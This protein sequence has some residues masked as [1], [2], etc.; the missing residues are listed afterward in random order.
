V[1]FA[2]KWG[3]HGSGDGQFII[4]D[5]VA[6][7]SSGNVYVADAFNHRIQKFQLANPC[8]SSTTQLTPKIIKTKTT[9]SF[10]VRVFLRILDTITAIYKI[11]INIQLYGNGTNKEIATVTR[12]RITPMIKTSTYHLLPNTQAG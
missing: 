8:P 9:A 3:S 5:G 6:V 10:I 1:C 7:D 4:P 2:T 11:R 12:G